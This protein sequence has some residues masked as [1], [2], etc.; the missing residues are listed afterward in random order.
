MLLGR[1]IQLCN[2][3][4]IEHDRHIIYGHEAELHSPPEIVAVVV[5]HPRLFA[6][7]PAP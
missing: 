5:T 6:K 7:N 4:K 3:L 2:A 1:C